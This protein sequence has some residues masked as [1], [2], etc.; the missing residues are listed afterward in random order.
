MGTV[1]GACRGARKSRSLDDRSCV[2][3]AT[4]DL[5]PRAGHAGRT[6]QARR[7]LLF[8]HRK[9]ITCYVAL[10]HNFQGNFPRSYALEA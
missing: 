6:G 7:G 1:V 5:P 9:P 8:A 4:E 2:K 10:Q 3:F